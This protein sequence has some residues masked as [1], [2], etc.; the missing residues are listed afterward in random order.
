MGILPKVPLAMAMVS[1]VFSSLFKGLNVKFFFWS[2]FHFF[3]IFTSS[4]LLL[5]G[6]NWPTFRFLTSQRV[7]ILLR[8]QM[9]QFSLQNSQISNLAFLFVWSE[10]Y[11]FWK[12]K[13]GRNPY[14]LMKDA[15]SKFST[16]Q[17]S[18]K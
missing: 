13:K 14:W 7:F 1:S 11:K 5:R 17:R 15:F 12:H 8:I 3:T 10:M 18:T 4:Y 9:S 2:L 6:G 16:N